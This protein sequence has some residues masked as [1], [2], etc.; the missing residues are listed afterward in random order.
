MA[1]NDE[2]EKL[3]YLNNCSFR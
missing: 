2:K 3:P 1:E